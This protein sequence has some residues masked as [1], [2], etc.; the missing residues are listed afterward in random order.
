MTSVLW[1][2]TYEILNLKKNQSWPLQ[3]HKMQEIGKFFKLYCGIKF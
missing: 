2:F 1:I 3:K